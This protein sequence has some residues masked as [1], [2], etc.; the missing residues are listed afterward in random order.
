MMFEAYQ[1]R[2]VPSPIEPR[3]YGMHLLCM[4]TKV[5]VLVLAASGP[6]LFPVKRMTTP[7]CPSSAWLPRIKPGRLK[8]EQNRVDLW[9]LLKPR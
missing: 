8:L 7:L 2:V 4:E 1:S 9:M 6:H 3:M 5:Q